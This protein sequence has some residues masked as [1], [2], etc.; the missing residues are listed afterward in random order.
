MHGCIERPPPV[1]SKLLQKFAVLT[2]PKYNVN[3]LTKFDAA[4][5]SIDMLAVLAALLESIGLREKVTAYGVEQMTLLKGTGWRI[6]F[7]FRAFEQ[8]TDE[9]ERRT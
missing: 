5:V 8:L 9:V 2:G 1:S 6:A 7:E 3:A 4:D